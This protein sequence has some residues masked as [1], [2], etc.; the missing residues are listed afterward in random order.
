MMICDCVVAAASSSQSTSA[1]PQV[2]SRSDRMVSKLDPKV[3][4]LKVP[5]LGTVHRYSRSGALSPPVP[6][7]ASVIAFG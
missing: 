3:S 7:V 1:P 4:K 2:E 6:H 5:K